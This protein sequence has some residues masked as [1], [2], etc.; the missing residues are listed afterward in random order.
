VD[1]IVIRPAVQDE[2]TWVA[3][4][5]RRMVEEMASY[6]GHA[7]ATA[8]SA[9]ECLA[10]TVADQINSADARYLIAESPQHERV[11]VVGATLA[12]LDDVLAPKKL[13]HIS[14]VYVLPPARGAGIGS[15]LM[16]AILAWGRASG[17]E[18]CDLNVVA[19]NPAKS[20]YEK[21]GFSVFE[22]KMMRPL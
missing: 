14:A 21:H 5:I 15:R 11:G 4:M 9:W 2:A 22:F 18:L 8:Q 17:C 7:P 10:R 1:E 19:R 16:T 3:A 12:T 20:L 6:G 13:L